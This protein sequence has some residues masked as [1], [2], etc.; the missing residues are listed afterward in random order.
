MID[1]TNVLKST[2]DAL[3]DV[4]L[5]TDDGGEDCEVATPRAVRAKVNTTTI[6]LE[7]IT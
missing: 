3:V 2:L 1:P 5:L 7:D 6:I 4:G